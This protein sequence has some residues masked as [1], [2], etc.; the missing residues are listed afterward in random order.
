MAECKAQMA[1]EKKKHLSTGEGGCPPDARERVERLHSVFI[2]QNV[3]ALNHPGLEVARPDYKGEIKDIDN[4]FLQML[5][6]FMEDFFGDDF[7]AVSKPLGAEIT[8]SNFVFTVN[9]F[10]RSFREK[11]EGMQVGL[12]E[13]FV[14]VQTREARD[15]LTREYA[16]WLQTIA[17]DTSVVEPD[18]LEEQMTMTT[19]EFVRRFRVELSRYDMAEGMAMEQVSELEETI[20]NANQTRK[21]QNDVQI[22]GA[23]MKVFMSPV[24]G[25]GVYF[26]VCHHVILGTVVVVG[27]G[28]HLKYKVTNMKRRLG[29][30]DGSAVITAVVQ[31]YK[32]FTMQR[33][34]DC[35][36]ISVALNARLSGDL[37]PPPAPPTGTFFQPT[38]AAA[39]SNRAPQGGTGLPM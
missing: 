10:A 38:S 4:D 23:T 11:G 3:H 35:Q 20:H 36:A 17:P 27:G 29:R 1:V 28:L 13:A 9:N 30:H 18:A 7:P 8:V 15:T 22:E 39:S 16:T 19:A 24:V 14:N 34:K 37:G 25:G 5:D 21:W 31:D 6:Q 32:S 26:L 33:Y 2:S 12:R